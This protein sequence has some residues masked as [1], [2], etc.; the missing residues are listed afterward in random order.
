MALDEFNKSYKMRKFL[1]KSTGISFDLVTSMI[2]A[3][4]AWWNNHEA[5][6][7]ITKS[8]NRE[9]PKFWDVIVRC[10]A[11][12]DVYSQPQYYV[13][14][15]RQETMNEGRADDS[16]HGNSDFKGDDNSRP[17]NEFT[18]ETVG[19]NIGRGG[20]HGVVHILV[21]EEGV[22]FIDQVE[23]HELMLEVVHEEVVEN[24]YLR[25]QC[26]TLSVVLEIFNDKVYNNFFLVLSTKTI[27]M[28]RKRRK[29]CSLIY[30]L[31]NIQ[32][33]IGNVLIHSKSY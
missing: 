31:Q 5:G 29:R 21:A 3:S 24:N 32:N 14:Q 16:T 30:K 11:L 27:M 26:K 23:A 8:F 13:R 28:N 2:Y 10:F 15:R 22:D 6:Y 12:H 33:F 19:I 4:P 25:Q 1:M 18:Y 20:R 9:T 17:S 7:R